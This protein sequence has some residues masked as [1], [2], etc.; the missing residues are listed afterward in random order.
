MPSP[1]RLGGFP[2]KQDHLHPCPPTHITFQPPT[3]LLPVHPI[4]IR[5]SSHLTPKTPP[6]AMEPQSILASCLSR[7]G[8][9]LSSEA[10][11]SRANSFPD[12]GNRR[13]P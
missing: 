6:T 9:L 1:P 3:T 8:L 4:H 7:G 11:S 5:Y 10:M 13:G 12:V 2:S